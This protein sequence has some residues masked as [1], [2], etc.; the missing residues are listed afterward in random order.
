VKFA[1][2]DLTQGLYRLTSWALENSVSLGSLEILRPSLED[3]YLQL[4]SSAT[5]MPPDGPATDG[6]PG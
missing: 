3:V 1:P 5:P 2:A 4:T 6:T